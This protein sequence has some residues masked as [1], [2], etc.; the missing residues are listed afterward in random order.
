MPFF[1]PLAR[2]RFK[3]F[4]SIR[5]GY[6]SS[7]LLAVILLLSLGAE[8]F[9][10]NK[11]LLVRYDGEYLFPVFSDVIP[12]TTFGL[13]Y[14]YE[15]NYRALKKLFAK[16]DTDNF[17]VMPLVPYSPTESD[18][19]A[20]YGYPPYPPHFEREHFLGTDSAGRDI[21]ALV[22]Y[23]FRIAMA[24][25]FCL[26]LGNYLVGVGIGCLM[27][28][29]GGLFDLFFQRLIEIWSNIPILYVIIIIASI[30]VPNFITLLAI[31]IIFGW[32]SMT[33]Y[34]RTATYKEKAREYVM[35]AKALGAGNAR[36][37]FRHI[38]PNTLSLIVTFIPFS[39]SSGI[40]SLTSLDYLGFGLPPGSPSWGGLLKEGT[41]NLNATW[42]VWS[43]VTV[44]VCVL[45]MVTFIG[46][47]I[48]EA[49]DPKKYTTYE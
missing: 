41:E 42:I 3:R 19:D 32:T 14:K 34:M 31:M 46:E 29:T 17:V 28:Y 13:D 20:K 23:G 15:T 4:R 35:A 48:R 12:G 36:I 24:F 7:I 16:E 47:A 26:L 45:V 44:M 2:R 43:V 37:I 40:V 22:V 30:M 49:V 5:R 27:G 21:L 18:L 38:L 8:L 10:N 9:I 33:W 1:T 6:Y 11:A 25:S 39:I